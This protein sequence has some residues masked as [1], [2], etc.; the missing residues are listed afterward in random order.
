MVAT[1][2]GKYTSFLQKHSN[3]CKGKGKNVGWGMRTLAE[4]DVSIMAW[5]EAPCSGYLCQNLLIK[6]EKESYRTVS[7][8]RP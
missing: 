3:N 6:S 4:G 1:H 2:S 5:A 8:Q 7:S